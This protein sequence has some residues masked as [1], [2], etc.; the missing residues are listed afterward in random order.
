MM[1]AIV[2]ERMMKEANFPCSLRALQ[3]LVEPIELLGV[4]VI[5][6]QSKECDLG[7]AES[8]IPF[9][10]HVERFVESLVVGIIMI[11]QRSV[12]FHSGIEKRLIGF[13]ELL[14]EIFGL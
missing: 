14:F 4:H 1:A 7:L 13:L 8:I 12:E 10:T 3:V 6:V 5:A 2:I 11:S 9:A